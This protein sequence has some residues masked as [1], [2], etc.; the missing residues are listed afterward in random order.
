[1]LQVASF[2]LKRSLFAP[3]QEREANE[4]MASH[5]VVN[6]SFNKD[7]VIV[8]VEDG[9]ITPAMQLADLREYVRSMDDAQFQ[10][11]VSLHI[12]ED[13]LNGL[14][15]KDRTQEVAAA[16]SNIKKAIANQQL[17]KEFVLKRITELSK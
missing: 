14:T 3:S 2:R 9:V 1:M 11:E 5:K 10:Q 7:T 12:L 8:F 13:E 4:F 17:K 6:T 16:I 15:T